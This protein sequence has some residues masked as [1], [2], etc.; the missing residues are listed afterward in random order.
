MNKIVIEQFK[1]MN[2]NSDFEQDLWSR[3]AT[4]T[5]KTGLDSI[6]LMKW[7]AYYDRFYYENIN[8]CDL[9]GYVLKNFNETSQWSILCRSK[10]SSL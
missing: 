2:E 8:Y 10:R 7:L 6:R 4:S 3:T 1:D 5:Y 9:M